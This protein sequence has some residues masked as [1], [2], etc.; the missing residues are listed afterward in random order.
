MSLRGYCHY[1]DC[2]T[3]I[4]SPFAFDCHDC[5]HVFCEEHAN[6]EE[7]ECIHPRYN[8]RNKNTK[9]DDDTDN[10]ITINVNELMIKCGFNECDQTSQTE[11]FTECTLCKMSYCSSHC[12]IGDHQCQNTKCT[13]KQIALNLGYWECDLCSFVNAGSSTDCMVCEMHSTE[14]LK[15]DDK[16]MDVDEE[17]TNDNDTDINLICSK[18]N[19]YVNYKAY[20]SHITWCNGQKSTNQPKD[21][22]PQRM[23]SKLEECP[24]CKKMVSKKNFYKVHLRQ[25]MK[26][27]PI[28]ESNVLTQKDL[29]QFCPF[30]KDLIANKIYTEHLNQCGNKQKK[31]EPEQE[32]CP[33][34]G[35][36][37][38]ADIYTEHLS[39]CTVDSDDGDTKFKLSEKR[40]FVSYTGISSP[41]MPSRNYKTENK[42]NGINK[43]TK[44][45]YSR[46]GERSKPKHL[47]RTTTENKTKYSDKFEDDGDDDMEPPSK[48]RRIE[49]VDDDYKSDVDI[50]KVSNG[51]YKVYK[52]NKLPMKK[53]YHNESLEYLKDL[54]E[55]EDAMEIDM[56][57][58]KCFWY[59][60]AQHNH[61]EKVF[62]IKASDYKI[63]KSVT[64]DLDYTLMDF[65]L[66]YIYSGWLPK[67][68]ERIHLF[69]SRFYKKEIANIDKAD[70]K[71][72]TY[73]DFL[74]D[75]DFLVIPKEN[76]VTSCWDVIIVCYHNNIKDKIGKQKPCIVHWDVFEGNNKGKNATNKCI[77]KWLNMQYNH[78]YGEEE[79][80][81][82]SASTMKAYNSVKVPKLCGM[83]N[84]NESGCYQ[85][86][87]FRKWGIDGGYLNTT[88][89][90]KMDNPNWFGFRQVKECKKKLIRTVDSLYEM[91]QASFC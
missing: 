49:A 16:Q 60:P 74:F 62:K 10:D 38:D 13:L 2:Q 79:E 19:E 68:K 47:W 83:R 22:I 56:D 30:C 48:K 64:K 72:V 3:E 35:K 70:D 91:Q 36:K 12:H 6:P 28:K 43:A 59:F 39:V 65:G 5:N 55:N 66:L 87:N 34:C 4:F 61:K 40:K 71:D 32:V 89:K 37:V 84:N 77:R 24:Y 41:R 90:A 69:S 45:T 33:F 20:D 14:Q 57:E 54:R 82:F 1:V 44:R 76:K 85:L 63:L 80:D 11:S 58:I 7:H 42:R 17:D 81:L 26:R 73:F 29:G 53:P 67:F 23:K 86:L 15:P 18:C 9:D 46:R 50:E 25:C 78:Q 27:N 8:K 31:S 75:K 51:N 88:S 52:P 21:D